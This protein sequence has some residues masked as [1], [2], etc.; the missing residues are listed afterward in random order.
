MEEDGGGVGL[1]NGLFDLSY[2]LAIVDAGAD[3]K[4]GNACN[5]I[6]EGDG[7]RGRRDVAVLG[8]ERGGE[9]I[10]TAVKSGNNFEGEEMGEGGRETESV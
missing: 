7:V 9:I 6:A 8:K 2:D 10:E 5:C 3:A 1:E 4:E